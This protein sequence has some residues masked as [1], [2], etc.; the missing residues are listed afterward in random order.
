MQHA[1]PA[2][3]ASRGS[4]EAAIR[5]RTLDNLAWLRAAVVDSAVSVLDAEG[6]WYATLRLPRTRDEEAWTL[7][8]LEQDGVLVHPGHFFDFDDEAYVIVSLLTPEATL[9]DGVRR[10][11]D[12]VSREA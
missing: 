8:F 5:R 7:T 9:R 11:L 4:A 2:L 12:R 3:L 1:L 10:I 6:G